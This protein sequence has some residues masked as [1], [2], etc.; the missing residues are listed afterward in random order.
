MDTPMSDAVIESTVEAWGREA[1][2]GAAVP[3]ADGEAGRRARL[4]VAYAALEAMEENAAEAGVEVT[5]SRDFDEF[6]RL[7]SLSKDGVVNPMLNPLHSRLDRDAFWLRLTNRAGDL[8]GLFG[9]KVFRV[10]DVMVLVR[11]ERFWFDRSPVR[12]IDPRVRA[13]PAFGPFG[14][15]VSHGAGAWSAREYR[16]LGVLTFLSDYS[17]ALL[18]KDYDIDWHTLTTVKEY[19]DGFSR[20]GIEFAPLYDGWC[21][22]FGAEMEVFFGRVSRA[23]S[24]AR[25][26]SPARLVSLGETRARAASGR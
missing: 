9:A 21:N 8:V 5:V 2:P 3:A 12:E 13:L 22:L 4:E 7:R 23:E 10:E 20:L 24:V 15:T 25:L 19:V 6:V 26:R 1:G 16:K 11:N 17:R 18:V 14:G